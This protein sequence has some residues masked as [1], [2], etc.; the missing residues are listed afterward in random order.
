MRERRRETCEVPSSSSR[1]LSNNCKA[2]MTKNTRRQL[3]LFIGDGDADAIERIRQAFNP[4]QSELI[5]S[6]VTLC[7]E[8]EIVDLERIVANL[9]DLTQAEI[10]I[11][12]GKATRF[13]NGKGLLLPATRGNTEFQELRRQ[14]LRGLNDQPR[15]QEPHITL[16]HPRNSVCTDA[17]FEEVKKVV[18]PTELKFEKISLIEQIDGGPWRILQEFGLKDKE[19]S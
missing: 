4:R 1:D 6:H 5:R 18:L 15:K 10:V 12:F 16:M 14:I 9:A 11:A 13:D 19:T 2:N 7:R 3:T 17:I 8:D